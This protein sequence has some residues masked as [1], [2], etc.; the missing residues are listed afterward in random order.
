MGIF[1]GNYDR[2]GPG[3]S[4]NAPEKN[5]FFF[6]F[7]IL[8]R[9]FSKLIPLNL[10]YIITL[11][12]LA[13]GVLFSVQ[14]NPAMFENGVFI[15]GKLGEVNLFTFTGDVVGLILLVISIFVAGPATCG[16]T[17][18]L[19]NMQRAEHTWIFS[20]FRERFVKNFKQGIAMSVI[21]IF[22]PMILYIAYCFYAYIMPIT[23]P[24]SSI[25]DEFG[26]YFIIFLAVMFIMMHYYIYTM[27]VTF[28][29]KLKDILRNSVIFAIA[30][31]PLNI[32]IT[33][34]IILVVF[35]SIWYMLPGVLALI[36]LTLSFLGFFI[37]YSVYPTIESS[38]ITPQLPETSKDDEES[39]DFEDVV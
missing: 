31:L 5:R 3:V 4:K 26:K 33:I 11:I 18:V 10:L 7:E 13:I 30:K 23:M 6:F 35:L 21:D 39:K 36:L 17:F 24:G 32:F 20:D 12:P 14:I 28:E 1:G 25:M 22:V 27:I 19:R 2:V 29:M 38:M 8:G 37:V 16:M 34:V 15:P 9:K